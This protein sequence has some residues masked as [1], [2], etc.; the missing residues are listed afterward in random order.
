LKFF[1]KWLD[2]FGY[3]HYNMSAAKKGGEIMNEQT[4]ILNRVDLEQIATIGYQLSRL[5]PDARRMFCDMIRGAVVLTDMNQRSGL[6]TG[7]KLA[8]VRQARSSALGE[9][10]PIRAD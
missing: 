7:E 3:A 6:T 10:V 4:V 2:I 9:T 5:Q 8:K 1:K